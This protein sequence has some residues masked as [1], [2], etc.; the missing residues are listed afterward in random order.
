MNPIDACGHAPTHEDIARRAYQRYEQ[1]NRTPG[2]DQEDW[3]QAE[4]ELRQRVR[5]ETFHRVVTTWL[6]AG[7]SSK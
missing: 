4:A 1:R 2:R 7:H 3:F 5:Q 6:A